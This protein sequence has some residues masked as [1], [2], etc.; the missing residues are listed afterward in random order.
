MVASPDRTTLNAGMTTGTM[1]LAY[2]ERIPKARLEATLLNRELDDTLFDA[3]TRQ[4]KSTDSWLTAA[5]DRTVDELLRPEPRPEVS[6]VPLELPA[7][8]QLPPG[9][10]GACYTIT[11]D[12]EQKAMDECLGGLL[13]QTRAKASRLRQ[14][15][16]RALAREDSLTIE[17]EKL[18]DANMRATLSTE[19]GEPA[20][21][22]RRKLKAA[23]DVLRDLPEASHALKHLAGLR[24][25]V[26]ELA[27]E[28]DA[29]LKAQRAAEARALDNEKRATDALAEV[30]LVGGRLDRAKR[31]LAARARAGA[32]GPAILSAAVSAALTEEEAVPA[33]LASEG[34]AGDALRALRDRLT[35]MRGPRAPRCVGRPLAPVPGDGFGDAPP[36]HAVE[37]AGSGGDAAADAVVA[38]HD[39]VRALGAAEAISV[40]WAAKANGD[41]GDAFLDAT[42]RLVRAGVLDDPGLDEARALPAGRER[43]HAILQ[44]VHPAAG[45]L[46]AVEFDDASPAAQRLHRACLLGCLL[47]AATPD[48]CRALEDRAASKRAPPPAIVKQPVTTVGGYIS[49]IHV[50]LEEIEPLD[51]VTADTAAIVDAAVAGTIKGRSLAHV[52]R[53]FL[54][55]RHA[56][57]AKADEELCSLALGVDAVAG[58]AAL[59]RLFARCAGVPRGL[60]EKRHAFDDRA[61]KNALVA[62]AAHDPLAADGA[63]AFLREAV[64]TIVPPGKTKAWL[65]AAE[66]RLVE[67]A[68]V[69]A[70]APALYERE[71][72]ARSKLYPSAENATTSELPFFLQLANLLQE[73]A[74]TVEADPVSA[75]LR[76]SVVDALEALVAQWPACVAWVAHETRRRAA[77]DVQRV[78]RGGMGRTRVA[79]LKRQ[80]AHDDF[81]RR[82]R[83]EFRKLDTKKDG[84]FSPDIFAHMVK[85]TT[86][87][88]ADAALDA[89]DRAVDASRRARAADAQRRR[90][91]GEDVESDDEDE[92]ALVVGEVVAVL[93]QTDSG[94]SVPQAYAQL[95]IVTERQHRIWG[96]D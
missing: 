37:L 24:K 95:P 25:D 66:P 8:D 23:R 53:K 78:H 1:S 18:R 9:G 19:K 90:D 80:R 34:D 71:V 76:V 26:D 22:A 72:I 59:P 49:E 75:A 67:L 48:A 81:E 89:Y 93:A 60:L 39:L 79:D 64:G 45:A 92:D 47:L 56:S 52:A 61:V 74:S 84:L 31:E 10:H 41:S 87:G 7:I 20:L 88:D 16:R 43:W 28:R 70:A 68:A 32:A 27:R 2:P 51:D 14:A 29:A 21:I 36:E 58:D 42:E 50:D 46:A 15:L 17:N 3:R 94:A 13:S 11:L 96:S 86:G 4:T 77:R 73:R 5:Q 54:C 44:G 85:A 55:R 12:T 35:S 91:D 30:H 82:V 40:D 33:L 57:R 65:G 62:S 63:Y 69:L 38:A 83:T 6:Q